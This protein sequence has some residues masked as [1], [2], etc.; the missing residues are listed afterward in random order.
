MRNSI[1]AMTFMQWNMCH[2]ICATAFM[3]FMPGHWHHG[4]PATTLGPNIHAMAFAP[5]HLRHCFLGMAFPPGTPATSFTPQH[6]RH[7]ICATQHSRL[8]ICAFSFVKS[9]FFSP[10][11][12]RIRTQNTYS[13][14]ILHLP[15]IQIWIWINNTVKM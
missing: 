7:D 11:R 14:F 12:I 2:N 5:W 10:V 1:C 6:S 8:G 4:I 3:V 13:E 9:G 15:G